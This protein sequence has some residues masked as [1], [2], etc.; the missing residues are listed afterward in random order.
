MLHVCIRFA[1]CVSLCHSVQRA[2][3]KRRKD[4]LSHI[5]AHHTSGT[6]TAGRKDT[7]FIHMYTSFSTR[8]EWHTNCGAQRQVSFIGIFILFSHVYVFFDKTQMAHEQR[9][10]GPSGPNRKLLLVNMAPKMLRWPFGVSHARTNTHTH[11]HTLASARTHIHTHTHTCMCT[12]TCTYADIYVHTHT[13]LRMRAHTTTQTHT[14]THTHIH[15]HIHIHIHA[16]M[17]ATHKWATHPGSIVH[18]VRQ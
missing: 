11:T 18:S 1:R 2:K 13:H 6:P 3:R 8:L 10:D 9:I 14:H 16:H 4:T 17:P 15:I 5:F 12:C 7:F